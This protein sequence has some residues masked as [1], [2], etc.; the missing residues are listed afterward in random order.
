M[1]QTGR[2]PFHV[3]CSEGHFDVVELL[4]TLNASQS[5]QDKVYN[6]YR[7]INTDPSLHL[8]NRNA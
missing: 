6:Y 5:S 2:T 4:V 3:A 8:Y 1:S 7:D